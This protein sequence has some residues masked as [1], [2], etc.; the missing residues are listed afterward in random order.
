MMEKLVVIGA[1]M[2]SGRALEHLF[3]TAP[4]RFAVTLFNTE[5]RG[6]YNRLMLSPVL[7]GD[8]T[9]EDIVTHDAD[10]YAAHGVV[11]RFGERVEAIDTARKVVIG[12]AG[13]V[14]Y[15][16]VILAT[17]LPRPGRHGA[18]GRRRPSGRPRGCDR[19]RPAGPGS[20]RRP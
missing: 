5:P 9:A 8:K 1:G 12:A 14:A 20:G 4:G 19:R 7:S 6:N 17:A 15:D 2:A 11:C 16:R 18:H 3:E 10:W 13:E